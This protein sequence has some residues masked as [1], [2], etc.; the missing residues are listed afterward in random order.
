MATGLT[1][2]ADWVTSMSGEPAS[3]REW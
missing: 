1:V 2:A 3:R